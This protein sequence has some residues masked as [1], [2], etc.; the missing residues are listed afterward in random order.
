MARVAVLL[1]VL[2]A[3]SPAVAT[4]YT[5]GDSQGWA[6]GVD[7]ST[8]VAGKTFNVG[9]TLLFQYSFMHD[10]AEV[11]KSDYDGCSAS[12][13]LQSY[14]DQNT[15]ILL[16]KPGSRYFICG[17]PGHCSSGMKLAVTVAAA[18]PSTTPAGGSTPSSTT[19]TTPT[20]TSPSSTATPASAKPPSTSKS[21]TTTSGAAARGGGSGIYGALVLVLGFLVG[22]IAV[23]MG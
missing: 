7:Y 4:D 13:S 18:S 14:S 19:P 1:M 16:S 23:A 11:S 20:T 22:N 21:S 5:V 12:N 2:V 17:T 8:W 9:D 10:V 6:S 15:K 3:V